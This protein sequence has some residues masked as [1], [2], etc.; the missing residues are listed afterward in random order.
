V[1][2][3][4]GKVFLG[5]ADGK[6]L[7]LELGGVIARYVRLQLPGKNYFH[8]DEV[9]IYPVGS[10]QN[11]ALGKR[12]TQSSVSQWSEAHAPNVRAEARTPNNVRAEARTPNYFTEKVVQ[13]A[14]RLAEDLGNRGVDVGA[15]K[16]GLKQTVAE[17]K[18]LP[19]P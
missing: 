2:R 4:N 9:E 19:T 11:I 7:R 16:E 10:T 12:A 15:E 13:R 3:N 6:P 1:A 17:W 18:A 14:L 5:Y 8:L